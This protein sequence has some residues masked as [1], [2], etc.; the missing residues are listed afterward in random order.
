[1]DGFKYLIREKRDI[2]SCNIGRL[3]N[4]FLAGYNLLL[5][6]T[7]V[8]FENEFHNFYSKALVMEA[9]G[10][11]IGSALCSKIAGKFKGMISGL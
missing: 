7:D 10:G 8:M 5:P 9:I 3:V 6:Y 2:V 11:V 4:F 1:M